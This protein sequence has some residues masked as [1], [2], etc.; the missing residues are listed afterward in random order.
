VG[1]VPRKIVRRTE[2][3]AVYLL[4]SVEQERILFDVYEAAKAVGRP[5]DIFRDALAIGMRALYEAGEIPDNVLNQRK[6]RE[7]LAAESARRGLPRAFQPPPPVMAP[8]EP[9]LPYRSPGA[10]S[11]PSAPPPRPMAPAV[12]EEGPSYEDLMGMMGD[13]SPLVVGDA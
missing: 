9:V 5:Q 10:E 12:E 2:R 7:R 1:S 3:V 13:S 11:V 8:A 4:P 6:L